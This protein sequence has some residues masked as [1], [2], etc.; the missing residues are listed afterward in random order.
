MQ[1]GWRDTELVR[2]SVIITQE[3]ITLAMKSLF[4]YW[5]DSTLYPL[6]VLCTQTNEERQKGVRYI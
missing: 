3:V 2:R 6:H 1:C 4:D 5:A